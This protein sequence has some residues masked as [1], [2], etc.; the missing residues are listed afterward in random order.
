MLDLSAQQ[1]NLPTVLLIDDDLV[2]REVTATLLTMNGYSVHT[3]EDGATAVEMLSGGEL[4]PGVILMDAQMPG[5]SGAE[6]IAELR[7][8]SR[9]CLYTIS[10]SKPA[11][12]ISAAADGFL[13]KPFDAEALRK[14][15]EGHAAQSGPSFLDPSEPAISAEVLG[16]FRRLM[17]EPAVRQIYEAVV[18][19]LAKRVEM[20][21][22]AI[23]KGD[24]A[25]LRR[26][27]HSIKGGCGMA[28]ALQAAHIGALLEALPAETGSIGAKGNHLD[29]R[30][31]LVRDL[32]SAA[33][34]LERILE[35]GLP[36]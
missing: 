23:A 33:R 5:L 21:E 34:S 35:A 8:R 3:A 2:S 20:L 10:A 1:R 27:G 30:A 18:S 28:G 29:N 13:L 16:Q 11:G 9:A 14:L 6:L 22:T 26:L 24:T 25:E 7:A 32:R 17:P 15:L 12:E 36:A 4:R 19:D 31:A